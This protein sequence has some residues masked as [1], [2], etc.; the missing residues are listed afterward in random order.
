MCRMAKVCMTHK[1]RLCR[2]D[3]TCC[4]GRDAISGWLPEEYLFN[5][6]Q[7]EI[8]QGIDLTNNRL[9]LEDMYSSMPI[10][11]VTE[12]RFKEAKRKL[13]IRQCQVKRRTICAV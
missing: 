3:V 2:G 4:C 8:R 9:L 5:K 13:T 1:H 12:Y 6:I 10:E 11:L 7:D